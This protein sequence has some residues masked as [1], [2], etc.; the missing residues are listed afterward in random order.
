M[1]EKIPT[2]EQNPEEIIATETTKQS[3]KS[4]VE[5]LAD[6]GR[7][8]QD[9]L[10]Q[11][12]VY[13]LEDGRQLTVGRRLSVV[14]P[15]KLGRLEK[16]LY[17][18]GELAKV[19]LMRRL[20]SGAVESEDYRLKP[21]LSFERDYAL[22]NADIR[23]ILEMTEEEL[24]ELERELDRQSSKEDLEKLGKELEEGFEAE[25]LARKLGMKIVTE[26]EARKINALLQYVASDPDKERYK[27][28][29]R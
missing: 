24:D 9:G 14:E 29:E 15:E 1:T 26:A 22:S 5:S 16:L 10:S 19:K 7:I 2:R 27:S 6:R 11:H 18:T 25:E 13:E 17:D 23:P 28:A 20:A 12:A 8:S 4:L 3:F 21:D